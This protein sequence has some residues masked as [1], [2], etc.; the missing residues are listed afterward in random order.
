MQMLRRLLRRKLEE[1]Q[2]KK[3]PEG[4]P[5]RPEEGPKRKKLEEELLKLRPRGLR[6][7]LQTSIKLPQMPR[8]A[9]SRSLLSNPNL[10]WT[11]KRC[12]KATP[13]NRSPHPVACTTTKAAHQLN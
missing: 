12:S 9:W 2:K 5:K 8:E 6:P 11:A 4:P 10:K 7:R 3:P 13:R 1:E